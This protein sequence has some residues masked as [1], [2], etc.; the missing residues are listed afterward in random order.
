MLPAEVLQ[1][2][3]HVKGA[4]DEVRLGNDEVACGDSENQRAV[5]K[6]QTRSQEVDDAGMEFETLILKD[7]VLEINL[8]QS[9]APLRR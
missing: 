1:L 7:L 2:L 9:R 4:V 8:A 6:S 5:P 3:F